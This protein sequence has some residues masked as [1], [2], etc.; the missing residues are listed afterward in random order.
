MKEIVCKKCETKLPDEK[1]VCL[2]CG[3]KSKLYKVAITDVVTFTEN[4]GIKQKAKG[5]KN[6]MVEF[7]SR[8]K[9]SGD[10]QKYPEGVIEERRID[11]GNKTYYQKVIDKKTGKVTHFENESLL[12]HKD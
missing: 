10:I 7:I 5:F 2:K 1:S 4:F 8:H 9:S 11:K 6:F 12:K 3:N